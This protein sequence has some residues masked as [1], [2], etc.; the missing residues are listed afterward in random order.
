MF[1]DIAI[2]P[3]Q[4]IKESV[5]NVIHAAPRTELR[6][7]F[8]PPPL[9]DFNSKLVLYSELHVL[10]DLLMHKYGREFSIAVMENRDSCVSDR[11]SGMSAADTPRCNIDMSCESRSPGN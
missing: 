10:R 6:G 7:N 8:S 5:C 1:P 3:C 2:I 9:P 4:G 11:V